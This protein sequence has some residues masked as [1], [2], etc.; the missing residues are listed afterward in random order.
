ME[1]LDKAKISVIKAARF[2]E[3]FFRG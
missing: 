3:R 1:L 2:I